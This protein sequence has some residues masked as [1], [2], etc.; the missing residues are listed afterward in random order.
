MPIRLFWGVFGA[1]PNIYDIEA[2][3]HRCLYKKS[4]L[5]ICV[6]FTGEQPCRSVISIILQNNFIEITL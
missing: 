6:K 4:V 2:A 1:L 5:E 3:F